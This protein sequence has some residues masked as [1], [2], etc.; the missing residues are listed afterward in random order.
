[1]KIFNYF[2]KQ[3]R[4]INTEEPDQKCPVEHILSVC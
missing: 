1:L 4:T 2:T 3:E